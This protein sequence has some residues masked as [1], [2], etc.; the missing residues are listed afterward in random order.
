VSK[1][2]MDLIP[3]SVKDFFDH[4][5]IGQV[6]KSFSRVVTSIEKL[7][8]CSTSIPKNLSREGFIDIIINYKMPY[9]L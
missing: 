2:L 8:I 7:I 9:L 4:F 1:I 3:Y 5:T 6:N